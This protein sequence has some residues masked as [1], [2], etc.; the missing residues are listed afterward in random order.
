M[1]TYRTLQQIEENRLLSNEKDIS[2][3]NSISERQTIQNQN[4]LSSAIEG[5]ERENNASAILDPV[6][7]DITNQ[8]KKWLIK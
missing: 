4:E 7:L 3:S 5:L 6:L 2:R 8:Q 1:T